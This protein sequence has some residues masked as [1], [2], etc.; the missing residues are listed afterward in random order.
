MAEKGSPR[1]SSAIT[2]PSV[3]E[4]EPMMDV[5]ASPEPTVRSS[6]ATTGRPAPTVDS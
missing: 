6:A 1:W 2:K 4:S 3:P 5:G